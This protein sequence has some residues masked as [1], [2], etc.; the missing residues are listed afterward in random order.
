MEKFRLYGQKI[1]NTMNKEEKSYELLLRSQKGERFP[2]EEFSKIVTNRNLHL[3][4]SGW[5]T[6]TLISILE[7]YP[8]YQFS[9][10]LDH[11]ELEYADT[12]EMLSKL[13]KYKERLIIEITEIV[14]ILRNTS[15]FTQ[16]NYSAFK[17]IKEWGFKIAL[18]D[19][20]QGMNS[21][22]NLIQVIDMIDRIKFSTLIFQRNID[23]LYLKK[24]IIFIA[25]ISYMAEKELVIEGIEDEIFSKWVGENI[26]Q[27]HQG[28]F[29][30]KPQNIWPIESLEDK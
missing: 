3:E 27:L 23:E 22:G 14:P 18:D 12:Y 10:N 24:L 15:Y 2:V 11:Q 20:G 28:Y 30:S 13:V 25:D 4:Y 16:I 9:F 29:Y 19:V 8:T 5:F 6:D 17:Q 1:E 21:T 7:T 26:T